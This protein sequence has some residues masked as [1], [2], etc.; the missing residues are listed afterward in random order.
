[1]VILPPKKELRVRKIRVLQSKLRDWQLI[2]LIGG[3]A[4]DVIIFVTWVVAVANSDPY[5][6]PAPRWAPWCKWIALGVTISVLLGIGSIAYKRW[7]LRREQRRLSQQRETFV[8]T[9]QE[10]QQ[11]AAQL[12]A[13]CDAA[14]KESTWSWAD[15]LLI[16]QLRYQGYTQ[17]QEAQ[18]G[19]PTEDSFTRTLE[20]IESIRVRLVQ[21]RQTAALAKLSVG[22]VH[23]SPQLPALPRRL[24]TFISFRS[25]FH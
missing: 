5:F 11:L 15:D 10:L 23:G 16:L 4:I 20:D 24:S 3:V 7:R 2:S 17:L 9:D 18:S 14:F 13:A 6:N 25:Q 22:P 12:E 19:V 21:R 8:I 1:M